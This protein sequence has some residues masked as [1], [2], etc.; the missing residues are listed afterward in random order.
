M[1][2]LWISY[3]KYTCSGKN[4]PKPIETH[5]NAAL[6]S[7]HSP[8]LHTPSSSSSNCLLSSATKKVERELI[9]IVLSS[10]PC[11]CPH[12]TAW[13]T[14]TAC[15]DTSPARCSG[16]SG[17]CQAEDSPFKYQRIIHVSLTRRLFAWYPWRLS[18]SHSRSGWC[19]WRGRGSG[20]SWYRCRYYRCRCYR[21]CSRY[22]QHLIQGLVLVVTRSCLSRFLAAATRSLCP[23]PWI[24]TSSCRSCCCRVWTTNIFTAI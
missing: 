7:N 5:I 1:K 4:L 23:S 14:S 2:T 10:S 20:P 24:I 18:C 3:I 17:S 9:A 21:Y 16:C 8:H 13:D 11:R 15:G 6:F 22:V 19:H 12:R